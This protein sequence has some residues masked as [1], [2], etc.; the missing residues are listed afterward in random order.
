M[1]K[2]IRGSGLLITRQLVG[3]HWQ[4]LFEPDDIDFNSDIVKNSFTSHG[5]YTNATVR[6]NIDQ[7]K[8]NLREYA[9]KNNN[10]IENADAF[11]VLLV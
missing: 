1:A 3:T 5:P 6:D 8:V 9:L 10:P 2:L 4:D 7:L 11:V